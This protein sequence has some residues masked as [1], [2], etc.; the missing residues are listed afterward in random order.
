MGKFEVSLNDGQHKL[1]SG[2]SGQWQGT[3]RTW[4]E[5]DDPVDESPIAGTIRS[6]LEGRFA[7]HEYNSTFQG[8]PLSGMAI[9]GYDL[10]H[11]QWQSVLIDSFHMSTGIMFL[12]GNS[13]DEIAFTGTYSSLEPEPQHWGWRIELKQDN[14]DH[15]QITSYNITPAGESARAVEIDYKRLKVEPVN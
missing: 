14:P 7:L 2:I 3:A 8:K 1:L 15:L 13:T 4:F 5:G 10:R 6:I 12:Q 11:N 9:Y